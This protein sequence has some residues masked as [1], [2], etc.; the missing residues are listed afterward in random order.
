MAN[1]HGERAGRARTATKVGGQTLAFLNWEPTLT[2]WRDFE[3]VL[4]ISSSW[5][6]MC[7]PTGI[8]APDAKKL[9]VLLSKSL[10]A[11]LGR[12]RVWPGFNGEYASLNVSYKQ[13]EIT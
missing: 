6:D 10:F 5:C 12:A 8:P 7:T 4:S 2:C 11:E 3:A 9:V 1:S 13:I